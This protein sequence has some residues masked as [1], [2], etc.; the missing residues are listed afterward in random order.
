MITLENQGVTRGV[1][2][3][4]GRSEN[5][6]SSEYYGP[7]IEA[8]CGSARASSPPKLGYGKRIRSQA[9]TRE[10]RNSVLEK[11]RIPSVR[12]RILMAGSVSAVSVHRTPSREKSKRE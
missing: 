8:L 1:N 3:K 11:Q 9:G 7:N 12:N 10:S 4:F 2:A 6:I 5:Q